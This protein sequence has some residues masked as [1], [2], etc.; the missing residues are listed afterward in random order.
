MLHNSL[1][2]VLPLLVQLD[3][4]LHNSLVK[5]LPSEMG[6]TVGCDNFKDSIIDG[7][8]RHIEGSSTKV[9]DEDILLPLLLVHTIGNGSGGGFID[10]THNL[11]SRN[12]SSILGGLSLSV[13]EVG[14]DCHHSVGHLLAEVGLSCL[15][16]L[17]Q[18]HGADLFGCKGLLSLACLNL[19]V[20]LCLFLNDLKR[21]VLQIMLH[22]T[23]LEFAANKTLGIKNGVLRIRC[24][25]IFS[26]VSN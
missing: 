26:S 8:K 16:H 15:L 7:K 11:H 22:R 9:K 6:V 10:D 4:M 23:I 1:V 2:K 17:G 3:E 13:V 20:G 21:E 25:L 19:D 24:Q 14:G 18:H 12:D 5:V